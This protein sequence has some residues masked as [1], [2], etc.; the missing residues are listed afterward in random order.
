MKSLAGFRVVSLAV[1]IPG[2]FAAARLQEFGAAITKIEPLEGDPLE[3]YV[4]K[5]YQELTAGQNVLRL[6]L[7]APADRQL[8][9]TQLRESDLLLTSSRP[10]GLARL[11][12]AWEDVH[13]HFPRLCYVAILGHPRPDENLPGHDLTYQAAMGLLSPPNMPNTLIADLAGAER[14]C[15]A[16]L[17]LLLNRERGLGAA[18]AEVALQDAAAAFAT[19]LDFGLTAPGGMLGGGFLGY[20]LYR[21]ADNY[22]AVAALEPHF[23]VR[24]EKELG[25]P[26]ASASV[27]DSIF[28]SRSAKE[29]EEWAKIRDL[30]ITRVRNIGDTHS[31]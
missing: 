5:W 19:P 20:A 23:W 31:Y 11:G 8:L 3:T 13:L 26:I 10:A 2:P 25:V 4:H 15:S 28:S 17:S 6:N 7:K 29:W 1:N 27:L 22:I 24:L 9:D 18:Y 14:A 21:A 30:P 16:A 12:L